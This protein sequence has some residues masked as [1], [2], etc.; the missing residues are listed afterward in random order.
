MAITFPASGSVV[1]PDTFAITT[2][3]SVQAGDLLIF[4]V[5]FNDINDEPAPPTGPG[6][7]ETRIDS[8]TFYFYS[9]P[10]HQSYWY[11][12]VAAGASETYTWSSFNDGN[13]MNITYVAVRGCSTT[14]EDHN[15]AIHSSASSSHTSDSVTATDTTRMLL[16]M[17]GSTGTPTN[18]ISATGFTELIDTQDNNGSINVEIY[19]GHK[20]AAAGA[21]TASIALGTE[22][23]KACS[24]LFVLAPSSGGSVTGTA[25]ATLGGL[26]GTAAGTRTVTATAAAPLGRATAAV[27]GTRTVT[28]TAVAALGRVVGAA[29]GQRTVTGTAAAALGRAAASAS[30]TRTVL[31]VGAGALGALT[32][33]ATVGASTKTGTAAAVLGALSGGATGARTVIGA[34]AGALGGLTAVAA[35]G[36]TGMTGEAHGPLP[37]AIGAITVHTYGIAGA[38]V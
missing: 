8:G 27:V 1:T 34:G 11:T 32:A 5:A 31:G 38:V 9:A 30:A 19:A 33:A 35:S 13:H 24:M 23:E 2:S 25:V 22:A 20:T 18:N 17:V 7:A 28:G 4:Q 15:G 37:V 36:P 26:A 14:L 29:S 10:A 3:S 21:Q 6:S 12:A 16:L